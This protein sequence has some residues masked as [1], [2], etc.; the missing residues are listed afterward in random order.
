MACVVYL[1]SLGVLKAVLSRGVEAMGREEKEKRGGWEENDSIM[2]S[3]YELL[4]FV[5]LK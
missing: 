1:C 2:F 5:Y 4:F 3:F